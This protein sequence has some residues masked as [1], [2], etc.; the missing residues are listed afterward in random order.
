[1][2]PHPHQIANAHR[3]LASLQ[4]YNAALDCSDTGTGKSL[5]ALLT[6]AALGRTPF[7]ICPLSV[8]PGW[9]AK[10]AAVEMSGQWLNYEKARKSG[11]TP[12]P[13]ALVIFD[14][15][16]RCKSATS[17]QAQLLVRVS[18]TNPVLLLTATPF[19]SPMET[20]ALL[21]ALRASTWAGWYSLL[22]KLGCRRNRFI[23]NAWEWDG[24]QSAILTLREMIRDRMVKTA[25][26]DVTGFPELLIQPEAVPVADPA[27][28]DAAL[29]TIAG[30]DKS[31]L[32]KLLHARMVVE[33]AKVAAMSDMALDLDSQGVR[34]V[35]FF[36]FSEPLR[37]FAASVG[38]P[39][40]DGST[41]VKERGRIVDAWHNNFDSPNVLACNIAAA[42]EGIDL[43]D[44]IGRPVV[45][46]HSPTWSAQDARQA[47][48][49]IHRSGGK[50]RAVQRV[51]F[52]S[53]TIETR[54]LAAM[55]RKS[56]AIDTLTD[57]DLNPT[58]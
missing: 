37:E 24:K 53:G 36:N 18:A 28:V 41:P 22:P 8:G 55:Q 11:W 3:L 6:A 23:N 43:H 54:V 30:A 20:R 45:A 27:K 21:H 48:G 58:E 29:R 17:Q 52:A 12:P 46:L 35:A 44:T 39:V 9:E 33:S 10:L 14:E 32:T 26:Q 34:T 13:D 31:E 25:W 19:S 1:M 4:R 38:C 47:F 2:T 16:H 7:I 5:T 56:A 51:L 15:A 57:D 42:K 40:I 49:R 50:S